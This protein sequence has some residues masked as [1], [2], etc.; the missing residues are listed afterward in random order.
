MKKK[1]L[2][3]IGKNSFLGKNLY[4]ALKNKIN[5]HILSFKD[6]KKLTKKKN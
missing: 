6:F 4:I 3:I 5:T 2:L 1:K